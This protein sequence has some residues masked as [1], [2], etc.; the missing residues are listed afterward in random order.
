MRITKGEKNEK[1][2]YENYQRLAVLLYGLVV[3]ALITAALIAVWKKF[4]IPFDEME[5]LMVLSLLNPVGIVS[6]IVAGWLMNIPYAPMCNIS[7]TVRRSE[8]TFVCEPI[9]DDVDYNMI[10]FFVIVTGIMVAYTVSCLVTML[11][12]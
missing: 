11:M 6:G 3:F 7:W 9:D 8:C 12:R 10:F 4:I 2:N 5:T 1:N